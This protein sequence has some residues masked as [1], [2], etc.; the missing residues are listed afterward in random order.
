MNYTDLDDRIDQLEQLFQTARDDERLRMHP[1]V[2]QII[3]RLKEQRIPLPHTLKRMKSRLEQDAFED[4]F[5]N[6][7]V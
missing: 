3:R 1:E 5:D 2:Q 4:M 6:M 7:P